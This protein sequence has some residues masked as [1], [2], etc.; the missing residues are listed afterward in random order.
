MFKF[1]MSVP[2]INLRLVYEYNSMD[3]LFDNRIK[4]IKQNSAWNGVRYT[5][6]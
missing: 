6:L 2:A 4:L 3:E 5:V 1:E